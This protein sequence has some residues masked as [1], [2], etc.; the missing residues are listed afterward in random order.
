MANSICAC[1]RLEFASVARSSAK[2]IARR[3]RPI[4]FIQY[5]RV[6]DYL[7]LTANQRGLSAESERIIA[8]CA[9]KEQRNLGSGVGEGRVRAPSGSVDL[10]AVAV[11]LKHGGAHSTRVVR[12]AGFVS[13][14]GRRTGTTGLR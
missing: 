13:L 3:G 2:P 14:G 7:L 1:A 11:A 4:A 12:C 9:T 6:I 10:I 5:V 8:P